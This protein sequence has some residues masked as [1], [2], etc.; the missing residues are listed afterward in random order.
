MVERR[1]RLGV[2]RCLVVLLAATVP[3]LV[4][5]SAV[6]AQVAADP[7]DDG[8]LSTP[9]TAFA[10]GV[11]VVLGNVV[12][13]ATDL[14]IPS[15]GLPTA[16]VRTYNSAAANRTGNLGH[17]WWWTYG[18]RADAT[19]DGVQIVREDGRTDLFRPSGDGFAPPTGIHDS[20]RRGPDGLLT[21]TTHEQVE[22]RFSSAGRLER[23]ADKNGNALSVTYA[24]QVPATLVDTAGRTWTI[25]TDGS[26]QV[27]AVVDPA[28]R[29]FGYSYTSG[30]L[31]R[32]TDPLG[33]VSK[34]EYDAA[35]RLTRIID[36]NDAALSYRYD[37]NGR[38]VE[39]IGPTQASTSFA[40]ASGSTSVTDALGRNRV[41]EFDA[42]RRVTASFNAAG[43]AERQAWSE[44]NSRSSTTDRNGAV[45]TFTYDGNGN[46]TLQRDAAGGEMAMT[47]DA[48][49]R[50]TSKRDQLGR[51]TTL[52]YD[53]RGNLTE[54][55]APGNAKTTNTYD[56]AGRMRTSTDPGG[57]VLQ[58]EYDAFGNRTV[59]VDG[60]GGRTTYAYDAA[61]RVTREVDPD[62]RV[63]LSSYD[64]RDRVTSTTDGAGGI[65]RL[66][67]D[68]VG[69]RVSATD[70]RGGVTRYEF[71]ARRLVVAETDALDARTTYVH[72]AVGNRTAVVN[73]LG[74]RTVLG[75]DLDNRL[76]STTDSE[77]NR[78]TFARD[79][80]GNVRSQTDALARVTD[81][82]YDALGRLVRVTDA[83]GG[84]A[85]YTYD[86]VGNR[87]SVTDPNGNVTRTAYDALDRPLS[88]TNPVNATEA[89][90]Y[91]GSG[92]LTRKTDGNG[93][94]TTYEYDGA[95]R[96]TRA[97]YPEGPV[98]FTY[99]GAGLRVSM[100]DQTGTT[101]YAYDG[102][103][104]LASNAA[105][106]GTVAYTYDAGGN[107]RKL[108]YPDGRATSYDYDA[109]NSVLTVTDW[110]GMVS[111]FG[112]DALGRPASES[113][114]NGTRAFF[115]HDKA[116]RVTSIQ[117]SGVGG[118]SVAG[119]SY[120][121]DGAGNVVR[122]TDSTGTSDFTY[123]RLDRLTRAVYPDA[124]TV[125]YSYD[126]AGNRTGM[127]VGSDVVFS[128]YD[129]ANRLQSVGGETVTWDGN[130]NMLSKG[131][132]VYKYDS[133]N[134]LLDVRTADRVIQMA[135]DGANRRVTRA[136]D[137]VKTTYGYDEH[138]ELAHVAQEANGQRTQLYG[139]AGNVLWDS[140]S[141]QGR[142]YYHQ[143]RLGS[144][145]AMTRPDG[146]VAGRRTYDAFG[147]PRQSTDLPGSIWFAGEQYDPESQLIY[148]R[149]RYYD[150]TTGRFATSDPHPP[151]YRVPQSLNRY[152]YAANNP[153]RY[154]DPTGL[155]LGQCALLPNLCVT[156]AA[157]G[158][159]AVAAYGV[160]GWP[161]VL[162]PAT[163]TDDLIVGQGIDNL[164]YSSG[165]KDMQRLANGPSLPDTARDT[166]L[167]FWDWLNSLS[168]MVSYWEGGIAYRDQYLNILKRQQ[169]AALSCH[170]ILACFETKGSS[171]NAGAACYAVP[172]CMGTSGGQAANGN[173]SGS[174]RSTPRQAETSRQGGA[175]VPVGNPPNPPTPT[176]PHDWALGIGNSPRLEWTLNGSPD[177]RP[178]IASKVLVARAGGT[179]PDYQSAWITGTSDQPLGLPYGTWE[180]WVVARD[181]RG[182]VSAQSA[183]RRFTIES[184]DVRITDLSFIPPSPSASEDIV[185][186][187]C[188]EGRGGVGVGMRVSVNSATDGSANGDWRI[189][190]E[191][192]V[193]CF[194]SIDAPHWPTLPYADGTHR[195]RVEAKGDGTEWAGAAVRE[196]T[197]TL[198][199]RRPAEPV[200]TAP[201]TGTFVADRTVTFRWTGV[202]NAESYR[203]RVWRTAD[204]SATPL[205]DR[206]LPAPTASS[207]ETF[208]A[209]EGTLHWRVTA[210]NGVGT[211]DSVVA[212]L[213]IDRTAPTARVERLPA[214]TTSGSF[215]VHWSAS[216]ERSGVKC[217]NVQVREAASPAWADW[218]G[219][220]TL[221]FS[222]FTGQP[223]HTYLFRAR[224]HDNAGNIGA[225]ASD[226]G[227]T[228]TA[229][230]SPVLEYWWSGEY[231]FRRP[232]SVLNNSTAQIPIGYVLRVQLD[233][234]TS[235][236]ALEVYDA[237]RTATKG[238][239]VRLVFEDGT[240]LDRLLLSFTTT[241]VDIVFRARTALAPTASD[242]TS[243]QL[244]YGNSTAGAPP[245]QRDRVLYPESSGSARRNYDMSE[246]AGLNLRDASG[247][248]D[249]TMASALGWTQQ[250]KFGPAV[251]VPNGNGPAI[252]AGTAALPNSFT[253][254]FWMKRTS[255]DRG[256]LFGNSVPGSDRG[257]YVGMEGGVLK[258]E[259][260]QPGD[261]S[262][263]IGRRSLDE[264]TFFSSF[265]HIAVTFDG[266]N[267]LRFYID[268]VLD[269]SRWLWHTGLISNPTPLMIGADGADRNRLGS[270]I[271][272]FALREGVINYFPQ[273]L[274]SAVAV[275][276]SLG[277]GAA[278]P[279]DPSY[280]RAPAI[281]PPPD[282]G[283][284][285]TIVDGGTGSDGPLVVSGST[286]L[287]NHATTAV[288]AAGATE[289]TLGAVGVGVGDEV[290]V[291]QT[292]GGGHYEFR[293]ITAVNGPV[294]SLDAP[295]AKAYVAGAQA[296]RVP[297]FTDVTVPNGA[298][299]STAP[300]NGQYGGIL[301]LRV[302]GTLQVQAG[303]RLDVSGLGFRG[304][305]GRAF[306]C[307][308]GDMAQ[309]GEGFGGTG[310]NTN[311]RNENG[312]GG[313]RRTDIDGG[314]A[315]GGHGTVGENPRWGDAA[316]GSPAG[317][318]DA[319]SL[320]L[321]GGGGASSCPEQPPPGGAGGG[322]LVLFAHEV[323]VDDGGLIV[324]S[325]APGSTSPKS[326][327]GS[328]GGA[329][330]AIL[331]RSDRVRLGTVQVR[332][333]GGPGGS[334]GE[335]RFGGSG[336]VG[337][338]RVESFDGSGV[339]APEASRLT[340]TLADAPQLPGA[341]AIGVA[342][343]GDGLATVSFT[344]PASNGGSTITSYRVTSN[345]GAVTAS[346]S[347]SPV[348]VPGLTNGTMYT[349]TVR[350]VNGVGAGA[351]S[352]PSNGVRP[353]R[354]DRF[355]DGRDGDLT[356]ASTQVVRPGDVRSALGGD[357]P[358][359]QVTLHGVTT[360]PFNVG[361]EVLVVQMQGTS[362]GSYEFATVQGKAA[363]ALT[364]QR[365]LTNSYVTTG[366][367]RAQVIAV[368]RYRNV[369][370]RNG[371]VLTAPPWDGATG[372]IL[373][374][375][376]TGT[377]LIEPGGRIDLTGLGFRGGVMPDS[378]WTSDGWNGES[379]TGPSTHS[380]FRNGGGGAG[381]CDYQNAGGS[382]G[383]YG[384][385]G[386]LGNG[387]GCGGQPQPGTAYGTP[388]LESVYL[389]SGGGSAGGC[390]A[391]GGKGGGAVLV[392]AASIDVQGSLT[393][394]GLKGEDG[395]VP[396]STT[397]PGAGGG[398]GGSVKLVVRNASLGSNLVT[399]EGGGGGGPGP[400]YG[401]NNQPTNG[402][403][404]GAGRLRVEYCQGT[405]GTTAPAASVAQLSCNQ[406][407]LAVDDHVSVLKNQAKTIDV[408]ANDS[409]VDS[410]DILTVT[411][412]SAPAHGAAHLTA[413]TSVV[414]YTPAANYEGPDSFTY[415]LE[416][417]QGGA[418]TGTVHVTVVAQ[419][420]PPAE[421]G[422]SFVTSFTPTSLRQDFSGWVGTTVTVGP[423]HLQVTSL[424]RWVVA[425]NSGTH[426][427]KLVDA[428]TGVDVAGGSA[429]VPTAGTP[430]GQFAFVDLA[431]PVR[432]RA[433]TRY[434]MV[435]QETAGGDSWY[436]YNT[437]LVTT[438]V[439]A[440]TGLVYSTTPGKWVTGGTAGNG[441]GP[442]SF[443]YAPP[444]ERTSFVTSFTPTS[445]RQDFSGWVGSTV[446]V[447]QA[448]V[449]VTSLGR[450]VVAGNSGSHVVKLVDAAT[451]VDVVGGSV[452]VATAGTPAGRF[453]FV[454]L[455]SPVTL[456][457]NSRYHIVTQETAGGDSW[458][459][460]NTKLVT[461]SV[462]ANTG[463]VYST[464]PGK[465]VAGGTAGNGYGPTSFLYAPPAERTSFVTSFTPT[466]L[467]QDFS[468]WV[469][470]TV[471]VGQADVQV[472]SLGRWVVAG[473]SGSHV[474][475]LVDAATGVDVVGGSV[476]VATAG[477]PAG[478]FAFVDL[479]SPV[480][481]RANS[482]YHIVTQE[483]AGGD[484]WY[485]YNTKLVTTSVA[486]NTGLVYSTTP[487]KWVTGGSAGNGYGPTSFL[488]K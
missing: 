303:G 246:G 356:V 331:F 333:E 323:K 326:G 268:G 297:N 111:G 12:H 281:D 290:M 351:E 11:N 231:A 88:E 220:T 266:G 217:T 110:D 69:N 82:E 45:T 90:A 186:R 92:N 432:L 279:F 362:A 473:N 119:F 236:T 411:S 477:T 136:V 223:G 284:A 173:A 412:V 450:W 448:D 245:G 258:F 36:A 360:A 324:A 83:A 203:L 70:A 182:L 63:T 425:G 472:T 337:R 269:A 434:H 455:D 278:Q 321:G 84:R 141:D 129:A 124:P 204:M 189:L 160:G 292:R 397:Y 255:T 44:T 188:T 371:G 291:H 446:T 191:L 319:A 38:A 187:A 89:W 315:G 123:D 394:S 454:D 393:T 86:A 466:S 435:T 468:G 194:N 144:S 256:I 57:R 474:V 431:S 93:A 158:V 196:A 314:G 421:P 139:L 488:Y 232:L 224:A 98:T 199:H 162:K 87:T 467:R 404:G 359:G 212:T 307:G 400:L 184:A 436:N 126:P 127:S 10:D 41:F 325:G 2:A 71:D 157:V 408:K 419:V 374:F 285:P 172:A 66:T 336:G 334:G 62:G 174:G 263:A 60:A 18:V 395:S 230:E 209:D 134:R 183:H 339:T 102:A 440:S 121:Y 312:G 227:D 169:E 211:N 252:N 476:S 429:N 78:T 484:S 5:A 133:Q 383:S 34:Y 67:F 461:T 132:T 193:P 48:G 353:T 375:K 150:P 270:H 261:G 122:T 185:I 390:C 161:A 385:V 398:S 46:V 247:H 365:P 340:L 35:H 16:V 113:Q 433:N 208:A 316:G 386:G 147:A 56:A 295:L 201:P 27:T 485:N 32:A 457:A 276:P 370:V 116:D 24:G 471:T 444:A 13:Q 369:T 222:L 213:G 427:V 166:T 244:Y 229:V 22:F 265:H 372:G 367:S 424:G 240:E 271:S 190:K 99:D 205:A 31:V 9:W 415:Q 135:Y 7:I 452:S 409:D 1:Y 343:G 379:H 313:G 487:G 380:H 55:V 462:A 357:S 469:G 366:A 210:S 426:L 410:G 72:D 437:R 352:G 443:L 294:V 175:Y 322:S 145:A 470:S 289:L 238:D 275:E 109:R 456:R 112:Y 68:P 414:T 8:S 242:T 459:N 305:T 249:A 358:A 320:S 330:G 165:R 218:F 460:Y 152:V 298:K 243:Y 170:Q 4:A 283:P 23:I 449:Q 363:T 273:G 418:A 277:A 250:G 40:Y 74:H 155:F 154:T 368:P 288:G 478:R 341:P 42:R 378:G 107:L 296:V 286:A 306:P 179:H 221:G 225:F 131:A 480:T 128:T 430:A 384:T 54:S 377:M 329:G 171:G 39:I 445:L 206:T 344:P 479:D 180:W 382:G 19:A 416:D 15:T 61:G 164:A 151:D 103:S 234:S 428:V 391:D 396:P 94:V 97:N 239:D 464:T 402:G 348:V 149:A 293:R 125:T 405:T 237:S 192:G 21:L 156:L 442:T 309:Q 53:S 317:Q 389:G 342:V 347:R 216:D 3:Q 311:A 101:N 163:N 328:G 482:R 318:A 79:G 85:S 105:P 215:A 272:G 387:N 310:S 364:L 354:P 422:I 417:G 50:P 76:A 361:D 104:R 29:T 26:G 350:A 33:A 373:A 114:P 153:L 338:V 140:T 260:W 49:N 254:E 117:W 51:T 407:P 299:L 453:A 143:D 91:D 47:Y 413:A 287:A 226:A 77:G 420:P 267:E 248:A 198:Q 17:G 108:T 345:P 447:G 475:K 64:A 200:A 235:P 481:L 274:F 37:A 257:W 80:V 120:V 30:N 399:A 52:A 219:C 349:F 178:V 75:Y 438:S 308:Y 6:G 106:T 304:G 465:W 177:G 441:Y 96:L 137:G 406:V 197:Y 301:A 95:S 100:T 483:T 388:E 355:G 241:R 130:G 14:T 423:A 233:A 142:L 327:A 451:G 214:V 148:L 335:A 376:A 25:Q 202:T 458:Y 43:Q 118:A 403:A 73:A 58:M 253:V 262:V 401:G 332:A 439:A 282:P 228:R 251:V 195:V 300:W 146:S 181:D 81:Y 59:A 280:R 176:S 168:F 486:A 259:V 65:N 381:G 346:G 115:S 167:T 264:P 392:H 28:G 20:L 138:A 207:T 159:K 302:K 463:L